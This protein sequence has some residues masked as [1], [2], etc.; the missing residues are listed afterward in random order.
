VG[1]HFLL[2]HPLRRPLVARLGEA[3]FAALYSLVAFATLGATVWAYLRAPVTTP[4]WD[5]GD[6]LWAVATAAMLVASVLLMGS[7]RRPRRRAGCSR[8]PGT[9]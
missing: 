5:A 1:T 7:L 3:G 2:S 9:R 6:G 4:W 8:S